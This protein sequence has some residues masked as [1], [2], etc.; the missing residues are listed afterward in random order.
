MDGAYLIR[1]D[2]PHTID[3]RY[4]D[5]P[6]VVLTYRFDDISWDEITNLI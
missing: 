2:V 4:S 3:N 5:G 1:T 6:R